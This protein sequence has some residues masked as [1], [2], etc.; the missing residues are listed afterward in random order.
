M[1]VQACCARC[2]VQ[3]LPSRGPQN[4]T[5][6]LQAIGDGFKERLRWRAADWLVQG[7]RGQGIAAQQAL[8]HTAATGQPC[9]GL[10]EQMH[11]GARCC[12]QRARCRCP[13][14]EALGGCSSNQQGGQSECAAD[15]CTSSV[16]QPAGGQAGMM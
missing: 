6:R 16:V 9:S 13:E 15:P 2:R 10:C 7:H 3:V 5:D 14:W 12:G 1:P 11:S 8:Q 4:L